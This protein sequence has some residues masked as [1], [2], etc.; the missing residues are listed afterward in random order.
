M[1]TLQTKQGSTLIAGAARLQGDD[2]DG[3]L[4]AWAERYV[5]QDSDLR[6]ILGNYVEA[7]EANDNGHIFP[8]S[9]L[10]AAQHT[11]PG[12][13]L[14]M[15]HREHY[16]VGYFAG[17]ELIEADESDQV[18]A[19]QTRP[20][21]E[22]LAGMW[23]RRFPEEFFNIKRAHSEGNLFFSME[24]LPEEVSCPTCSA[25]AAFA[26]VSSETYCDHMRGQTAPKILH[27]PHF[28]GGAIIIP[29]V[30]PG[31]KRAD[32][33]EI[34]KLIRDDPAANEVYAAV[35]TEA[36][37]LEPTQWE[38]MMAMLLDHAN[39]DSG[40]K[41]FPASTRQKMADEHKAMPDGSFPI[42]NRKD[43]ANAI[44]SIGR[45]TAS[46]RNAV[47]AHIKRRAKALGATDLIPEGW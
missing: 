34:S 47:K 8:M 23:H 38:L 10:L 1:I 7:D 30:S 6:W 22:A 43:L 19:A 42:G 26:G 5:R 37:H 12:K 4:K 45:T 46:K 32:I 11:L 24:A 28:G 21:V 17:S 44:Q 25:R 18:A 9:E 14:N 15:L 3:P 13:P 36:P 2:G 29:P 31:W 40:G 33:K 27:R 20:H 16:I 39:H 35:A 41:K